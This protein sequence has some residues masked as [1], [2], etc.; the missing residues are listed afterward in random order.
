MKSAVSEKSIIGGYG[1]WAAA[2]LEDPPSLSFRAPAHTDHAQWRPKAREQFLTSIA[3]PSLPNKR[4]Q[5]VV[6][7]QY[8]FDDL[9]VEE[10]E[11]QL[12][13]GQKTQAVLL[14]PADA[15][16]PLPGVVGLHDHGGNKYLGHRKIAQTTADQ[17]AFLIQHKRDY[18][19][20][21]SWAN[22]LA[23][24]GYAV[25]VH[26]VFTFGSRRVRLA[27]VEGISWGV[28][29]ATEEPHDASTQS[30][31]A[32]N[33]WA[34]AHEHILAKSLFCAGLTWPGIF[35]HED[36]AAVDVLADRPDVDENRI[37]CCGLSGGG[38]RSVYL[39]AADTRIQ[40]AIP[41]G[42]MSTWR[43]FLLH[44][45]YTHTWMLYIPMLARHLD[46]PDI[47][48]L[49]A[50]ASTMVLNNNEDQL[51]SL[52]EMKRADAMLTEVFR[53]ANAADRY[54]GKFYPGLHK[55]DL[56]MQKDAFEWFDQWL[57][58]S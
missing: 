52:P 6:K 33:K 1:D 32:Y 23:K 16:E 54:R 17:P 58:D 5:V 4:P 42:F 34:G 3:A 2:Q 12:P 8:V 30:I 20:G 24:R 25:L 10:L 21:A 29:E 26:D 18:Y 39:G 56:E 47:L 46:F 44:K 55:F 51:F 22:A 53:K 50:P 41:V 28:P 49:R 48:S 7:N 35:V 27:D 57:R 19:G 14:K 31:E 40:C 43:D 15:S 36:I 9:H 45:S 13:Y 38:L 11:W 37:G